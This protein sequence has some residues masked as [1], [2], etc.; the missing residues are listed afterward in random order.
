[1]S[2]DLADYDEF[3]SL[4]E[5]FCGMSIPE[6]SLFFALHGNPLAESNFNSVNTTIGLWE[7][8]W[9]GSESARCSHWKL[10]GIHAD[11]ETA[12][13]ALLDGDG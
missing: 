9:Y 1:M 3:V 7:L 11:P 13:Q 12:K 6:R 2:D 5:V 10:S 8:W 4:W